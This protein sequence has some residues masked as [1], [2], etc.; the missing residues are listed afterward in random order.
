MYMYIPSLPTK[1]LWNKHA[2]LVSLT[3]CNVTCKT[4]A[5]HLLLYFIRLLQQYHGTKPFTLT[6]YQTQHSGAGI[7]HTNQPIMSEN[8]YLYHSETGLHLHCVAY[9]AL[10]RWNNT[11]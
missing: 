7:L 9:R 3:E 6:V 1:P 11:G 5:S 4:V 10:K 2:G 8:N